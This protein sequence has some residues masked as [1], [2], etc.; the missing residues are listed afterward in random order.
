M[1]SSPAA[2]AACIALGATLL[3][4]WAAGS[5]AWAE[6]GAPPATGRGADPGAPGQGEGAS[7]ETAAPTE[8]DRAGVRLLRCPTPARPHNIHL[9][10]VGEPFDLLAETL[11]RNLAGIRGFLAALG[12]TPTASYTTQLMGN[13]RGG[14]SHGFTYAGA[15]DAMVTLDLDRLLGV[16]GLSFTVGASWATGAS[17][18]AQDI[19]NVFP[20]QSAF[21]GTGTVSL[22]QMY[23]QQQLLD[24]AL[25]LAA[26]RLAP[27]STFGILPV[28]GNYLSGGINPI[29]GSLS[30]DD[31]AFA[32]SPPG[33]QWGALAAYDLTRA[34][35]IALGVYNTNPLAAAG[36]NHGVDFSFQ[37]GNRGV[38][39]VAQL[40]YRLN[41]ARGDAGMPGEYALGG[42]YDSNAFSSLS[43]PGTTMNGNYVIYVM[44]QQMVYRPGGAGSAR[45]LTVWGEMALSPRPSASPMP[46]LVAGGLSYQGLVPARGKDIASV[47][48]VS[49]T[50]SRYLPDTSAE[51]VIEVNYQATLPYG[52]SVTPDIQYVI[53]PGGSRRIGNAVVI[54]LQVAV[55]F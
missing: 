6:T 41:Q 50:F 52:V 12:I 55:T 4:A 14:V 40:T 38:L 53:K 43:A 10:C 15:L 31:S 42:F 28:A 54:G 24:A 30:I 34:I 27:G 18:S 35:Q 45:G 2:L 19:G 49:G 16:P 23:L 1:T 7:P 29:H 48:V 25:T 46:Y 22:Q 20:V 44:A 9:E 8:D 17:L 5:P 26:G 33:V 51:T 13:P 11:T 36:A 3:V 37:Q 21:S 32:Q 39:T 47:G